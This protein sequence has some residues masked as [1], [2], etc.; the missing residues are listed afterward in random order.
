MHGNSNEKSAKMVE[1]FIFKKSLSLTHSCSCIFTPPFF[2]YIDSVVGS[3]ISTMSVLSKQEC[4]FSFSSSTLQFS[5][6][7]L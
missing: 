4:L 1:I 7:I 6:Y 2:P 3:S 5:C